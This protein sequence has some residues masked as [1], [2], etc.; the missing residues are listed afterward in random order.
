MEEINIKTNYHTHSLYCDGHDTLEELVETALN[1][2]FTTLGFSSHAMLPFSSD[3]HISAKD[4]N[5]YVEEIKSLKQKYSRKIELLTGFEADYINGVTVPSF[6]NYKDY[7]PDF[8]IGSVHYVPGK[9][10]FIEADGNNQSVKDGIKK[11]FNGSIKNAVCEYFYNER[12]MLLKG[13]FTFLGHADLIRKQNAK[14]QLF[15]END[16]WYKKEVKALVKEIAKT[17]VCVEV[18]TGGIARKSVNYL[19]PSNYMLELLHQNNVPVTINS[20]CHNKAD[21]DCYFEEAKLEIKKAGY[22]ELTF[23]TNGSFQQIKI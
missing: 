4:V 8:L 18:N 21:L 16:S 7:N 6:E 22:T 11:Y 17:D 9:D 10:G 15:N 20:D 1:K 3:W 14:E 13:D 2:K 5:S 12:Q 19:Y 23:Y